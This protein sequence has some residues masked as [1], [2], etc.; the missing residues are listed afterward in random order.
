MQRIKKLFRPLIMIGSI[1]LSA[2]SGWQL[3]TSTGGRIFIERSQFELQER[4]VKV[5]AQYSGQPA[6]EEAIGIEL[7][8]EPRNWVVINSL[9]KIAE[10]REVHLSV[11]IQEDLENADAS[12]NSFQ[13]IA[14]ECV[15]CAWDMSSCQLSKAMACGLTVTM[16]PIGDIAGI[17]KAG[18]DYWK[19]EAVDEIDA[20]LSVIGLGATAMSVPSVGT[21]LIVK[22]GAGLLKFAHLSGNIPTPITRALRNAAR[23]GIDWTGLR[24]VRG[25]DDLK[26]VIRMDAL[27]PVRNAA[28]SI[29]E[30]AKRSSVD[31]GLYL[32]RISENVPELRSISRVAEV[33]KDETAGFL[34]LVGKNR[35]VRTTLRLADEV[36][37][38]AF[39][40]VGMLIS[41]FW[42]TISLVVNRA[43]KRINHWDSA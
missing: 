14:T 16:T 37:A 17:A 42:T 10:N 34:K 5:A 8:S 35:V 29:G 38:L 9:R 11:E 28:T 33:W 20:A 6:L 3:S 4:L 15:M 7:A 39:G 18:T 2:F 31:Q 40:L 43:A 1:G 36:Y 32:L 24:A 21:S 13:N 26:S 22:S 23:E 27:T 41:L 30:I 19:D 25:A 12:D